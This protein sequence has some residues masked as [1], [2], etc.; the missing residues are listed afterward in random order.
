MIMIDYELNIA[1]GWLASNWNSWYGLNTSF[2]KE[3]ETHMQ[4]Y[5]GPSNTPEYE[6]YK[7]WIVDHRVELIELYNST[8]PN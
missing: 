6:I 7:R 4:S 8:K 1:W 5:S 3:V 2:T